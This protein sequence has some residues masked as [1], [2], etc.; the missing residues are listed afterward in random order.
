MIVPDLTFTKDQ[1]IQW[2][3]NKDDVDLVKGMVNY[4]PFLLPHNRWTDEVSED[5]DYTYNEFDCMPDGWAIAFGYEMLCELREALIE[6]NYL[7]KYRVTQ[8]KEKF[9]SL[10]WYDFGASDKVY[11]IIRKYSN[12]SREVCINC[13]KPAKYESVGWT[14]YVCEDCAKLHTWQQYILIKEGE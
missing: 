13:G 2:L 10:R 1:Y 12:L 7:H 3:N 4:F 5:Y 14:S 6:D 8:I 9:G 11:E